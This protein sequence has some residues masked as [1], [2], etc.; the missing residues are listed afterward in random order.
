[1]T[2]ISAKEFS[3]VGPKD[4]LKEKFNWLYPAIN[5]HED[6]KIMQIRKPFSESYF[7]FHKTK[8]S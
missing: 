4:K 1:L 6:Y 2:R 7:S 8:L 3:A 5:E